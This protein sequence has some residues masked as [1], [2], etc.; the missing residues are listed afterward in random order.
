MSEMLTVALVCATL[1]SAH[2]CSRETALDVIVAPARNPMECLLQGQ[3]LVA[4]TG[5]AAAPD[6]YVKIACERRR[7]A[8]IE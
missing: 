7:I 4:R 2:E 6:T 8:A 3:A 1:V 5:L